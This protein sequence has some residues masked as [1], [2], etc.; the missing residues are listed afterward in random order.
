MRTTIATLAILLISATAAQANLNAVN[1]ST[2]EA[3][4]VWK[5][6]AGSLAG[7][8]VQEYAPNGILQAHFSV[9]MFVRG[10]GV[11]GGH[12]YISQSFGGIAEYTTAGAL[13]G[14]FDQGSWN[15]YGVAVDP[16]THDVYVSEVHYVSQFSPEGVPVGGFGSTQS[17]CI[18]DPEQTCFPEMSKAA[19]LSVNNNVVTVADAGVPGGTSK[20]QW[21]RVSS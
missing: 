1:E 17:T 21:M 13:V 8:E 15:P 5:V 7:G 18:Y 3:G 2:D 9:S 4:N 16:T 11:G 6:S 10:I 19:G 12:V 20:W 14:K